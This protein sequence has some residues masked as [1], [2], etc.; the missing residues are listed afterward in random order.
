MA[1]D[2]TIYSVL[3]SPADDTSVLS[4]DRHSPQINQQQQALIYGRCLRRALLSKITDKQSPR[5]Y[6][7]TYFTPNDPMTAAQFRGFLKSLEVMKSIEDGDADCDYDQ[8]PVKFYQ[9]F[10]KDLKLYSNHHS[11]A[12]QVQE[13]QISYHELCQY[14]W[15]K[16]TSSAR[17][18]H[19]IIE[20]TKKAIQESL[21]D[22]IIS[23]SKKSKKD[24]LFLTEA[25]AKK[26]GIQLVRGSLLSVRHLKKALP[27]FLNAYLGEELSN[28]LTEQ[29]VQNIDSNCDGVVSAREFKTWLFSTSDSPVPIDE[30]G[31]DEETDNEN[32]KQP[33]AETPA[34]EYIESDLLQTDG[35]GADDDDGY[36]NS[37][38]GHGFTTPE[39]EALTPM[40]SEHGGST[41]VISELGMSTLDRYGQGPTVDD[42]KSTQSKST[43]SSCCQCMLGSWGFKLIYEPVGE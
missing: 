5:E 36:G 21:G 32:D 8:T 15:R 9:N 27:R 40:T 12:Q 35:Y 17:H 16:H 39:I 43:Q 4:N 30:N 13:N 18:L 11:G 38:I 25:F 7:K 20:M 34:V 24:D 3:H 37:S 19:T 23:K 28:D 22:K 10:I 14:L 6:L 42:G 41:G 31:I 2:D 1:H 33:V 29:L 26:T